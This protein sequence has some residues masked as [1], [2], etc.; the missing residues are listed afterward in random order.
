[1]QVNNKPLKPTPPQGYTVLRL[2]HM[3]ETRKINTAKP[4]LTAEIGRDIN[5]EK[6]PLDAIKSLA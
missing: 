3:I 5:T 1:M 2:F 6:S 4:K